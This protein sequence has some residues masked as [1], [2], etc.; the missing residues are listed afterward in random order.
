MFKKSFIFLVIILCINIVSAVEI[1]FLKDKY[2]AGDSVQAEIN[3]NNLSLVEPFG[4]N[5]IKLYDNN[6]R[7]PLNLNLYKLKDKY[8]VFFDLPALEAKDYK[9][10]LENLVYSNKNILRKESFYKNLSVIDGRGVAVYPALI[11]LNIESWENPRVSIEIKNK[12]SNDIVLS[13]DSGSE[14]IKF[15]KEDYLLNSGEKYILS[16]ILDMRAYSGNEF[17]SNVVVKYLNNSY[18]IP[19]IV[20]KISREIVGSGG[21]V[22]KTEIIAEEPV[23]IKF[24]ENS[25]RVNRTL[26]KEDSVEGNLRFK[27]FGNKTLYNLEYSL[28]SDLGKIVRIEYKGNS[29]LDGGETENF[30]I[31][32]NEDKNINKNYFGEL[33]VK[34]G[35][36]KTSFPFYIYYKPEI[37]EVKNESKEIEYTYYNTTS[38]LNPEKEKSKVW[39]YILFGLFVLVLIYLA[40]YFYKKGKPE[41]KKFE[42]LIPSFRK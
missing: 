11:Y 14:N 32:I 27:N 17:S 20:N 31:Y 21:E 37:V 3:L 5:N 28:T 16:M 4:Y 23:E 42:S 29:V 6:E 36:I 9:F 18:S 22:A 19:I 10:V 41:T 34:S 13:F 12:D 39:I 35:S 15:N 24:I 38:N 7:I 33:V 26:R 2:M 40:Y 1:N 8:F 30:Y 25:D